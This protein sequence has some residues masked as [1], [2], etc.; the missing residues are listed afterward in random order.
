MLEYKLFIILT[1]GLIPCFAQLTT[2]D[3]RHASGKGPFPIYVNAHIT[4]S[5]GI[6]DYKD[7][8]VI[9][10]KV[11]RLNGIDVNIGAIINEEKFLKR[12]IIEGGYRHLSRNIQ[13]DTMSVV[14][15]EEV[16]SLRIGKRFNILYPVTFQIQGG[17]IHYHFS[18]IRVKSKTESAPLRTVRIGNSLN[19]FK[20]RFISG[21]DLRAR[22]MLFD[23]AGT[24][25]GL[26]IFAE[27]RYT[28]NFYKRD[29]TPLYNAAGLLHNQNGNW[30]YFSWSLGIVVPFA[31][32][33]S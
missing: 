29:P 7:F 5:L 19:E 25:G 4:R 24:P 3:L 11:N 13:N 28:W 16:A 21:L 18:T 14:L 17:T 15:R 10:D 26:G 2:E 1:F 6:K 9:N 30:S 22:L 23:P 33:I 31:L 12:F 8:S 27:M 20:R 32:R